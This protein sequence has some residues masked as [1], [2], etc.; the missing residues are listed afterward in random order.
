MQGFRLVPAVL[1]GVGILFLYWG[2]RAWMRPEPKTSRL[3]TLIR[4]GSLAIVGALVA[5]IAVLP[6]RNAN[7]ILGIAG[8]VLVLR[9]LLGGALSLRKT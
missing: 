3:Q 4:A 8:A 9:G 2:A 6:V 5:A 7:V 1:V